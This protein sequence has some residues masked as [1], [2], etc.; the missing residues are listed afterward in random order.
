MS[1]I[2]VTITLIKKHQGKGLVS[3]ELRNMLKEFDYVRMGALAHGGQTMNVTLP[4]D[5]LPELREDLD[6]MCRVTELRL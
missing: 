6:G 1:D 2:N 5:K 3:S 4:A